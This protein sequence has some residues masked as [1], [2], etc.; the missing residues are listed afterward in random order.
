MLKES[1]KPYKK[2]RAYKGYEEVQGWRPNTKSSEVLNPLKLSVPYRIKSLAEMNTDPRY[3]GYKPLPSFPLMY[4]PEMNNK[5]IIP[6]TQKN[7][8]ITSESQ[9]FRYNSTNKLNFYGKYNSAAKSSSFLL[10]HSQKT[11]TDYRDINNKVTEFDEDYNSFNNKYLSLG[12]KKTDKIILDKGN[13]IQE[14][15]KNN[16]DLYD[17]NSYNFDDKK[18]HDNDDIYNYDHKKY[19]QDPQGLDKDEVVERRNLNKIII[20]PQKDHFDHEDVD[21]SIGLVKNAEDELPLDDKEYTELTTNPVFQNHP[22]PV[23]AKNNFSIEKIYFEKPS[24]EK[25]ISE[26]PNSN[27]KLKNLKEVEIFL[28]NPVSN[29]S[30]K[31]LDQQKVVNNLELPKISY[32]P[33]SPIY[34]SNSTIKQEKR[35]KSFDL[36]KSSKKIKTPSQKIFNKSPKSLE[37]PSSSKKSSKKNLKISSDHNKIL[38][39]IVEETFMNSKI[40]DLKKLEKNSSQFPGNAKKNSSLEPSPD[41]TKNNVMDKSSSSIKSSQNQSSIK[42]SDSTSKKKTKNLL[43]VDSI[44]DY[45]NNQSL[46]QR[47]KVNS[48]DDNIEDSV[49]KA[50]YKA[51]GTDDKDIKSAKDKKLKIN[52]IPPDAKLRAPKKIEAFNR[53]NTSAENSINALQPIQTKKKFEHADTGIN[54]Y[55]SYSAVSEDRKSH[56]DLTSPTERFINNYSMSLLNTLHLKLFDLQEDLK[57]IENDYKASELQKNN[58]IT[59]QTTQKNDRKYLKK[60]M[61]LEFEKILKPLVKTSDKKV[62]TEIEDIMENVKTSL[63]SEG[64]KNDMIK[65]IK[66]TK[67]PEKKKT[68]VSGLSKII[69]NRLKIDKIKAE[70]PDDS[71][72]S[73][74]DDFSIHE[75]LDTKKLL[76]KTPRNRELEKLMYEM[77]IKVPGGSNQ[78]LDKSL[79]REVDYDE[80]QDHDDE[81]KDHKLTIQD[82]GFFENETEIGSELNKMNW[83]DAKN[84][85]NFLF[86]SQV[87]YKKIS[88]YD[89]QKYQ[90]LYQTDYEEDPDIKN[91][92]SIML[93]HRFYALK[94]LS[95]YQNMNSQINLVIDAS[96]KPDPNQE[97]ILQVAEIRKRYKRNKYMKSN[98]FIHQ[99]YQTKTFSGLVKPLTDL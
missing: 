1:L 7:R 23:L 84:I 52:V 17:D 73:F 12:Y 71:F 28:E 56:Y 8:I 16:G 87:D 35:I 5:H 22:R 92:E 38:S 58:N 82:L 78:I 62:D 57:T 37:T 13:I 44:E 89:I 42:D 11:S 4:L 75:T 81:T 46:D 33:T 80:T 76:I 34:Q 10:N 88:P 41:N 93:K 2:N 29:N 27:Q 25:E 64:I 61:K 48:I 85:K 55:D 67:K 65:F 43:L 59:K 14:R 31:S 45:K 54:L 91:L 18:C 63:F 15:I 86:S 21:E 24:D 79:V 47:A 32:A 6:N 98:K 39:P 40:Q 90:E 95:N 77:N 3:P 96:D 60:I 53:N 26:I 94:N 83:C 50:L 66:I 49:E 20:I 51:P 72:E 36:Q 30:K 9:S 68:I 99:K 70:S 97:L 74:S 69:K 19:Y